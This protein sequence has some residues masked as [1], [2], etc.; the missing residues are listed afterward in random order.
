[1]KRSSY[2]SNITLP[3]SNISPS[4]NSSNNNSNNNNNNDDDSDATTNYGGDEEIQHAGTE[5][6]DEEIQHPGK[7]CTLIVILKFVICIL[8]AIFACIQT[9]L[10]YRI[11]SQQMEG[12][13]AFEWQKY[14]CA[15]HIFS[16]SPN[17][18]HAIA[19]FFSFCTSFIIKKFDKTARPILFILV[20]A[21]VFFIVITPV[22]ASLFTHLVPG[23]LTYAPGSMSLIIPGVLLFAWANKQSLE[24]STRTFLIFLGCFLSMLSIVLMVIVVYA[25]QM[26]LY[27]GEGFI[28]SFV[29][30][31]NE[32]SSATYFKSVP[33]GTFDDKYTFIWLLL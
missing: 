33:N 15:I 12:V 23:I 27:D 18:V 13:N 29:E 3:S 26:K 17:V 21:E 28:S 10:D 19:A 22:L 16:N 30:S 1:M 6:H 9:I 32:R 5:A 7:E 14:Q 31:I 8:F 25:T 4:N 24:F 20:F 11:Y 2:K